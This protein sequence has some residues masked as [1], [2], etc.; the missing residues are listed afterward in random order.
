MSSLKK[1]L[2]VDD[3]ADLREAL[4]DQLVATEE[5]DV[6]SPCQHHYHLWR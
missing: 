5:F 3:D 4:A 6:F 2:M 1:I